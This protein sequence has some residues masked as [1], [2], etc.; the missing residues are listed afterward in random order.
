VVTLAKSSWKVTGVDFAPHAI[1]RARKKVKQSGV[2]ADLYL[3][4]VTRLDKI[5]GIFDLILDIGC[6]HSLPPNHHDM[7][8]N[9]IDRFLSPRGTLLLY[10]FFKDPN[11][12]GPGVSEND[13]A[14]FQPKFN[15]LDRQ[16]GTDRGIRPSAWL[17]YMHRN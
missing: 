6:F 13:L 2:E 12:F 5:A 1:H 16:D 10:V 9:N 3:E 15:L 17:T 7:Y 11:V 14:A 8:I 4:D